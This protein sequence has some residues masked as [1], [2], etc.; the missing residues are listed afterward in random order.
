MLKDFKCRGSIQMVREK[1][2]VDVE[3]SEL[4]LEGGGSIKF[5]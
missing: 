3:I 2:E 1:G 5:S 4:S